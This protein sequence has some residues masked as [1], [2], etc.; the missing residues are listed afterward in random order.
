V[1]D[2]KIEQFLTS[3]GFAWKFQ[4]NFPIANINMRAAESNPA[5]LGRAIDDEYALSIG[6][7]AQEGADIPA[8]VTIDTGFDLDELATGR[9]RISG[10]TDFCKPPRTALDAYRVRES[11]PC[12]IELLIRTIN[13]IE[14][15]RT[16][17]KENLIHMA[18][19]KRKHPHLSAKQLAAEF[20]TTST[21]VNAYFRELQM[22]TRGEELGI[23]QIVR[24]KAFNK[25]A[26]AR[27]QSIKN[28]TIFMHACLLVAK[29]P[30]RYSLQ[31]ID[32]LVRELNAVPEHRARDIIE[33]REE[34]LR[35]AASAEKLKQTRSPSGVSTKFVSVLRSMLRVWP[36]SVDKLYLD[37]LGTTCSELK[38]ELKVMQEALSVLELVV[39]ATQKAADRKARDE[40][41]SQRRD[42]GK[43]NSDNT[44][45]R[46]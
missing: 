39:E 36:G 40:E 10:V 12:R 42:R 19:M 7:A 13:G 37:G 31:A 6:L 1:R 21:T 32:A 20:Y 41:W 15:R 25:S 27:L 9:H 11:D 14:G 16:P 43:P 23:G 33:Q 38:R 29:H 46:L 44:S 35:K 30:N 3:R 2:P 8:I 17:A 18:E 26:K 45:R 22:E 24:G 34:D 28:D 5:R 4:A